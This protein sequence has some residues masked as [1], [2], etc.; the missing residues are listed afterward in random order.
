MRLFVTGA[1]GYIGG[2]FSVEA[3]KRKYDVLGCDNFLNSS[4]KSIKQIRKLK[5]ARYEFVE[6]D[7]LNTEELVKCFQSFK[8]DIIIHFAA[9]KNVEDSEKNYEIY[10]KNNVEGT[11]SIIS[12]MQQT[13]IN[14]IIYSSSAA[15]YGEQKVQPVSECAKKNPLSHYAETKLEAEHLIK[16]CSIQDG[17]KAISLRYFNPLGVHAEKIFYENYM[18]PKSNI[19]GNILKV[20]FGKNEFFNIYGSDFP[21][22]DGTA[23]RD[24]IHIEDLVRGHFNAIE[25]IE[26]IDSYEAFNLGTNTGVSVLELLE[27]FSEVSKKK[28]KVRIAKKRSFDIPISYADSSKSNK[29]LN[30]ATKKNIKEMCSSY[31]RVFEDG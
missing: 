17:F 2:T 8:P 10:Q 27:A 19:L 4:P 26:Y 31:L 5:P 16:D 22:T 28:L 12:A 11:S 23:I 1:A 3:L 13:N 14:R 9:L 30:W 15:I 25:H 6:L 24:Y 7:I 20:Y 18:N 29:I 21:T